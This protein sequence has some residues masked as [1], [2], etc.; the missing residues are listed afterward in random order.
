MIDD[1]VFRIARDAA[2]LEIGRHDRELKES[3]ARINARAAAEGIAGSGLPL[4]RIAERCAAE[5]VYRGDRAWRAMHRAIVRMGVRYEPGM[6][7]EL[8][9]LVGDMVSP[10]TS[11][12]LDIPRMAA[13]T[14]GMARMIPQLDEIVSE[15]LRTARDRAWHEIE[16]FVAS[17]RAHEAA[18]VRRAGNYTVNVY[19][20]MGMVQT[21]EASAMHLTQGLDPRD[22]PA[23][24]TA[25]RGDRAAARGTV[26]GLAAGDEPGAGGGARCPRGGEQALARSRPRGHPAGHRRRHVADARV[27]QARARC[28]QGAGGIGG[29]AAAVVKPGIRGL[30]PNS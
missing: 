13:Y 11:D 10:V 30:T 29:P 19:A 16:L 17:L 8:K 6:E 1:G 7:A 4:L 3:I 21:G 24:R 22:M 15:G 12:L 26:D 23:A 2:R 5:A 28:A 9:S 25:A 27:P 18:P 14:V 20:P